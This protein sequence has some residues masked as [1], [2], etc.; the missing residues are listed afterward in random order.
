V[1]LSIGFQF[2][3]GRE[4]ILSLAE[5]K[6]VLWPAIYHIQLIYLG[7]LFEDENELNMEQITPLYG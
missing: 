2:L 1:G 4:I 3:E 7:F 6:P 5:P